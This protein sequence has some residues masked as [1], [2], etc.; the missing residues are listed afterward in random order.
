MFISE[1]ELIEAIVNN[2]HRL[3]QV[4]IH[5]QFVLGRRKVFVHQIKTTFLPLLRR[6]AGVGIT[7][8]EMKN[9]FA[10]CGMGESSGTVLNW[11]EQVFGGF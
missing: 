4:V 8:K 10:A 9:R 5:A 2:L 3:S 1:F 11:M 7:T 6:A